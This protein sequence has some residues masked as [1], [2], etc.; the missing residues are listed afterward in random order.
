MLNIVTQLCKASIVQLQ[1][2]CEQFPFRYLVDSFS[3]LGSFVRWYL[4]VY[5]TR[6]KSTVIKV[7]NNNKYKKKKKNNNNQPFQMF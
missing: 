3:L 2:I 1:G 7:F 4:L 5:L 6:S